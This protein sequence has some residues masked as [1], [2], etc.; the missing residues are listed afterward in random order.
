MR[1][2]QSRLFLQLISTLK[3]RQLSKLIRILTSKEKHIL[4][5]IVENLVEQNIK[6]PQSQKRKLKR[7]TAFLAVLLEKNVTVTY[8]LRHARKLAQILDIILPYLPN[9]VI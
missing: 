7:Y 8:L 2:S 9:N 4:R 6:L 5:E 1:W 3:G